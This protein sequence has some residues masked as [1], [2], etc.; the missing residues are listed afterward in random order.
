MSDQDQK[1]LEKPKE[2]SQRKSRRR[3]KRLRGFAGIIKNQLEPLNGSE[4]FKENYSDFE[5]KILLNN[6]DDRHAAYVKFK[7]GKVDID[8]IKK[9]KR[10]ERGK[11]PNPLKNIEYDG[12]MECDTELFFAIAKGDISKLGLLK[13][14]ITRKIKG[15]ST[16]ITFSKFFKIA[17]YEQK[18]KKE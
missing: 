4:Y 8:S 18:K 11:V 12:Y 7:D 9:P 14:V 17:Y 1:E 2:K 15:V 16:M 3:K 6:T 13:M 5:A 10:K